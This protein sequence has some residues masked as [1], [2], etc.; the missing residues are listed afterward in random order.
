VLPR[1]ALSISSGKYS[2]SGV[3][4]KKD[5]FNDEYIVVDA[6][7]VPQNQMEFI[8][9][10]LVKMNRIIKDKF[11][12]QDIFAKNLQDKAGSDQNGNLNIDD[13]KAFIV[14]SCREDLIARRVS[15]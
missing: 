5:I 7:K 8:E 14:D 12:T 10:R 6:R 11:K 2:V 3:A 15:K 4:P 9:K 13:F 1:S